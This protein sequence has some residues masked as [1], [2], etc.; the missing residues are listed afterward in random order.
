MMKK[1]EVLLA[2]S[3]LGLFGCAK[4]PEY[5][6]VYKSPKMTSI[7]DD[8]DANVEYLY[9]PSTLGTPRENTQVSGF[10]QGQ[11]KIVK[12]KFTEEG[13]NVYHEDNGTRGADNDLNKLPVLTIPGTY[14]SFKCAENSIGECTNREEE[15][16][17]LE[18]N[19]KPY[20]TPDFKNLTVKEVNALDF[21]SGEADSC[22]ENVDTR[23]VDY[24]IEK[25]LINIELEKTYKTTTSEK[26]ITNKLKDMSFNVRFYYSLVKLENLVSSDYEP[27]NYPVRDQNTFGFFTESTTKDDDTVHSN[28]KEKIHLMKRWNPKKGKIVYDLGKNFSKKENAQV[29]ELTYKA[30]ESINKTLDLAQAGFNI[31]LR[32]DST[33][34]PGD[35]RHSVINLIDEALE[36]GLLGYGPTVANPRTGEIIRGSVNM[37]SGALRLTLRGL[38]NDMVAL[39]KKTKK[40]ETGTVADPENMPV[41][42]STVETTPNLSSEAPTLP[43]RTSTGSLNSTTRAVK[44]P[45]EIIGLMDKNEALLKKYS[46]N[47]A[48]V[49]E[50]LNSSVT[51]KNLLPGIAELPSNFF[52]GKILKDWSDLTSSQKK[53]VEEFIF[54]YI[55]TTTLIHEMGHNLGLRHNFGGS[56]DK[57]N[58]LTEEEA[59]E[60]NLTH[61]PRYSSIMDYSGNDLEQTLYFGKYDIAAF[62]FGYAR[63]VEAADGKIISISDSISKTLEE[64]KDLKLKPYFY[65]TDENEGLS[66][67]CN[68]FD[69]GTNYTEIAQ[70]VIEKYENSYDFLNFR[71]GRNDYDTSFTRP[72]FEAKYRQF[73]QLRSIFEDWKRDSRFLSTQKVFGCTTSTMMNP[74]FKASCEDLNDK[75]QASIMAGR[76]FLRILKT[77]DHLCALANPENPNVTVMLTP[78]SKILEKNASIT[79]GAFKSCFD[80]ALVDLFNKTVEIDGSS[81]V[82]RGEIGKYLNNQIANDIDHNEINDIGALGIWVDKLLATKFLYQRFDEVPG[83]SGTENFSIFPEIEDEIKNFYAHIVSGAPLFEPVKFTNKDGEEYEDNLSYNLTFDETI[84]QSDIESYFVKFFD[85]QELG[86]PSILKSILGNAKNWEL[87]L[88][89]ISDKEARKH[90]NFFTVGFRPKDSGDFD[91]RNFRSYLLEDYFVGADNS[92]TLAG[93]MIYSINLFEALNEIGAEKVKKAFDLVNEPAFI[94]AL[95]AKEKKAAELGFDGLKLVKQL[96]EKDPNTKVNSF[97]EYLRALKIPSTTKRSYNLYFE[98]FKNN[99]IEELDSVITKFSDYEKEL[100]VSLAD[101]KELRKLAKEKSE[102]VKSFL[103]GSLEKEKNIHLKALENLPS[104][105]R[106]YL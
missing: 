50:F 76:F 37:Y 91:N 5:E 33:L 73:K 1:F 23:L 66:P 74:L 79:K 67:Q 46:D 8:F 70:S 34:S 2:L 11:P 63:K 72:Y 42:P 17:K 97:K 81:Y 31:E 32:E 93:K 41:I 85:L 35:I 105:P 6:T 24:N 38:W 83:T 40:L 77:P 80:P 13:I 26:C 68:K 75:T 10:F 4:S 47:C 65:C 96:K 43:A 106:L 53:M 3:V 88:G 36:S 20:F 82:I 14:H 98:V 58:F 100:D 25:G 19:Q 103:D 21:S 69:E 7:A 44:V 28:R 60:H 101:S 84:K 78:L 30:F 99:S 55:Y 54:P 49:P 29:K 15:N 71:D 90:V 18:W 56:F 51:A 64:N 16:T 89:G 45:G 92:N 94:T 59:R 61:I 27:I 48:F 57:A 22:L 12:I 87:A 86:N 62:R 102:D 95:T 104:S 52:K 9:V 39:T